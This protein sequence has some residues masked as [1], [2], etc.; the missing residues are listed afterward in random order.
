[1]FSKLEAVLDRFEELGALMGTP[2]VATDQARYTKLAKERRQLETLVHAYK[3]YR[4]LK[5]DEA[6]HREILDSEDDEELL[7]L[8]REELEQLVADVEATENE[9]KILLV[10]RDPNDS[11]DVIIEIRGN[12]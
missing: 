5:Q 12:T 6:G 7:A 1:M 11:R 2:E 10:P 8:A 4:R 9:I 3:R